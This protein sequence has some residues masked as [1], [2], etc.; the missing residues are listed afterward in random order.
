MNTDLRRIV[1]VTALGA[2]AL[3]VAMLAIYLATGIGQDPLQA[4]DAPAE[5]A[6]LLQRIL[7]FSVR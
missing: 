5:Y 1:R 7:P 3:A 2:C 4:V 6:A